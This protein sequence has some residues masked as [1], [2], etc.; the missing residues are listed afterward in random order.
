MIEN[1]GLNY[2]H[3]GFGTQLLEFIDAWFIDPLINKRVL[4][5]FLF[6]DEIID[7][8]KHTHTYAKNITSIRYD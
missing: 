2:L 7:T 1:V 8:N 5:F 4:Q 6:E 3:C